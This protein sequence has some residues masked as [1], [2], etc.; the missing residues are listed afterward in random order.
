MRT[1]T[2]EA[3]A[4]DY[5]ISLIYERTRIRLHDGKEQLIRSR[6]GK[7]MRQRGLESLEDY[8]HYLQSEADEVE[9][10]HVVDALTT[11]FTHFLRQ[12]DHFDFMVE[13]ALPAVLPESRREFQVW[14]AGSATGEEPYSIAFY[15]AER[16]P[17]S[18]GW[19]WHILATD[20]STK[21]LARARAG[22]Y[23]MERAQTVP[24]E[25]LKRYCQRGTGDFEGQF[26]IKPDLSKRVEFRPL[27]LLG[28]LSF[29]APFD[30]IFCRNVMIYFDRPTQEQ[31]VTELARHLVPGGYLLI[32][33]AE[34]LTGLDVP[35]K[36]ERPSIY[37]KQ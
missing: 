27:N 8:C 7:R 20:I 18:L 5:I 36:C 24:R 9:F 35:F 15:L 30:L 3:M 13:T 37:R 1:P 28:P 2:A 23:P 19:D 6:L 4:F 14:S 17:Q 29:P 11:N 25:W 16:F 10:T 32:G 26:R 31:L 34:S 22:V 33:R 21:A 12:P